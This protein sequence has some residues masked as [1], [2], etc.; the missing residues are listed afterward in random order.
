MLDTIF[1]NEIGYLYNGENA[2]SDEFY[3]KEEDDSKKY[4]DMSEEK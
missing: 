2:W 1:N 3:I 4:Y